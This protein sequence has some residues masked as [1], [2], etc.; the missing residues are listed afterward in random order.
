MLKVHHQ[1]FPAHGGRVRITDLGDAFPETQ[2]TADL[3]EIEKADEQNKAYEK[4]LKEIEKLTEQKERNVT[5]AAL[6]LRLRYRQLTELLKVDL[7][8]ELALE[9]VENGLS[10]VI[11]T[12]FRP[13][14]EQLVSKLKVKA[15]IHGEQDDDERQAAIDS[16]QSDKERILVANIVAGGASISLHD[17]H[18][19]HP[20]VSLICPTDSAI[21]LHQV[22]GRIRRA[23]GLT[24]SLQR[25]IYASG[26]VEEK[27]CANVAGKLAAMSALNDGDL[28]EPDV[29]NLLKAA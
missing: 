4:M 29:L 21:H 24:K 13:T 1:F 3:Y 17:L 6:V 2:I 27:V 8:V 11:F 23:G 12:N 5:A 14:L 28:M 16:F 26:T 20:R 15:F 7:L 9:Y 18:G 22:F 10:V 25:I 19:N